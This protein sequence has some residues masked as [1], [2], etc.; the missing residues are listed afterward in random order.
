MFTI[1]ENY[2]RLPGS[3]LFS[4]I[5]KRVNKYTQEN[6]DKSIIRLGI[7]DVTLP[8]TKSVI[9]ALHEATDE[10]GKA[11]TFRGYGPEHGYDFLR[12]AIIENDYIPRG[13]KLDIDEIFI[14]DGAK[15]DCGNIGDILSSLSVLC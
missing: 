10:M 15:S 13:I 2:L 5:A 11:E 8:L 4:D 7:G 6:P 1:N 12:Q 14:S 3:Y 9:T